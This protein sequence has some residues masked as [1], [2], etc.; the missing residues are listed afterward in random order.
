MK[1]RILL[2]N[3]PI[4]DFAAYDFW[5]RPYGMLEVA[6]VIRGQAGFEIFDYLDRLHP[7]A[8][9]HVG[10]GRDPWGRGR[11][12]EQRIERPACLAQVPRHFRRFG[13]PRNLFQEFLTTHGPFDLALVQTVMTYWYLGVREVIVDLRRFQPKAR[14][15]L[16]GNYTT[17]CP[18]HADRLRAD[19]VLE[20]MDLAPLWG[21]LG[22]E[23]DLS[24]P[25][26][27][28]VYPR[29]GVGALKLTQGCPFRCTYCSVLQVYGPFK[30]RP[31]DR[32]MAEFELLRRCGARH[33]AFYDDALLYRPEE[34][35]IPFLNHVKQTHSDIC[36]HTPNALNARFVSKDLANLLVRA[37]VKSFYLGFESAST[38]WQ[39]GTGGKILNEEL[40]HAVNLLLTTGADPAGITAYQI[41]GHPSSDIQDLEASMGFVHSLGI[42]GMLADFS[43]IPG[44]PDGQACRPW[45]DLDEPLMHNKTAFAIIRLG[46]DPVNR[47]KELQ[48]QLNKD[49][50]GGPVFRPRP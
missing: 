18:D 10:L 49:I 42:R 48:R 37:G 30:S 29:L 9:Q 21:L 50:D 33:V 25:A 32:S 34:V 45:I 44:T 39:S 41:V 16:G 35:L 13:L 46:L 17:L 22:L 1:P 7:W 47:L 5:L 31:L 26:L 27:W 15:A 3:P 6:G 8:I 28:E 20:G 2:V 14:I 36:F 24:Q 4:L 12:H 40:T 43:P 11:F 19:L 23:P 38:A